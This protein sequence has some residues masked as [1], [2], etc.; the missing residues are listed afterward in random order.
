MLT[1]LPTGESGFGVHGS[2]FHVQRLPRVVGTQIL[3][4]EP[5]LMK[6]SPHLPGTLPAPVVVR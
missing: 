5:F 1:S 6:T 2:A 4:P 3:N